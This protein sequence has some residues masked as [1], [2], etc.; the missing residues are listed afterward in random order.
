MADNADD[1]MGQVIRCDPT[2]GW[3]GIVAALE[4]A[5]VLV[6]ARTLAASQSADST[7]AEAGDGPGPR[8]EIAPGTYRGEVPLRVPPGVTLAAAGLPPADAAAEAATAPAAQPGAGLPVRL[9]WHGDGSAL[10][11]ER[12]DGAR[13][14]GLHPVGHWPDIAEQDALKRPDTAL[15]HVIDSTGVEVRHCRCEDGGRLAPGLQLQRSDDCQ[16]THCAS[17]GCRHGLSAISSVG[18]RVSGCR[19]CTN[20][21][22]GIALFRDSTTPTRACSADLIANRC[23]DNGGAGIVYG[24]SDGHAEGNDCLENAA[25]GIAV[26]RYSDA[27]EDPSSPTLLANRCH[28]NGEAGI[29]YISSDGHAEGN[30]CWGNARFGIAVQRSE[31]A[32]EAPSSPT[33]LANRCHDNGEAGISYFSSDGHAEGNDCWGNALYG[34]ALQRSKDAPEAPSRPTLLANRCHQNGGFGIR[35]LSSDGQAEGNWCWANG[36]T[37]EIA[38]K[39]QTEPRPLGPSRVEI[40]SHYTKPPKDPAELAAERLAARPDAAL[41]RALTEAGVAD[42]ARL[43]DFLGSGCRGCLRRFWAGPAAVVRP[44]EAEDGGGDG[45]QTPVAAESPVD[46]ADAPQLYELR[47]ADE[48]VA[49]DAGG[50]GDRPGIGPQSGPYGARRV[51]SADRGVAGASEDAGPKSEQASTGRKHRGL[52]IPR[53]RPDAEADRRHPALG[54]TDEPSTEEPATP[55]DPLS[56]RLDAWVL[57]WLRRQRETDALDGAF[58]RGPCWA[59]ALFSV[60]PDTPKVLRQLGN[61]RNRERWLDRLARRDAALGREQAPVVLM[62]APWELSLTDDG[63]A[64]SVGAEPEPAAG[65]RPGSAL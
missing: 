21:W 9:D 10:R 39:E 8:V 50:E 3:D 52:S 17:V 44:A 1:E 22:S 11:L 60:L 31:N 59:L 12:A 49:A 47:W 55:P 64:A 63:L 35:Y 37:N 23:H 38:R 24:S 57:E 40:H 15:I 62:D 6:S 30:D 43:A 65:R 19:L 27:C 16:V 29:L 58:G 54:A 56:D 34:I 25:D 26:T 51:R 13:V 32:P 53:Y 14:L 2:A 33:L 41:V 36:L 46:E 4:Q 61:A 42:A 20:L 48:V 45:A 28:D 5:R 7:G 18:L